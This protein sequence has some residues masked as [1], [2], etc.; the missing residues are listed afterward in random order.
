MKISKEQCDK[1]FTEKNL[2]VSEEK[3]KQCEYYR[4]CPFIARSNTDDN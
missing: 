2:D 4:V 3:C 1:E